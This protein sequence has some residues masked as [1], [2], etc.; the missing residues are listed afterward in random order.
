MYYLDD[1]ATPTGLV[2]DQPD[3]NLAL[4]LGSYFGA[5]AS[6]RHSY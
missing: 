1:Q 5:K 6:V 3:P 2:A 4:A